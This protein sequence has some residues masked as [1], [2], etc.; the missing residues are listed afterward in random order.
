MWQE[1]VR[2]LEVLSSVKCLL[3]F[4]YFHL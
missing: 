4:T 2:V 3:Q 1:I